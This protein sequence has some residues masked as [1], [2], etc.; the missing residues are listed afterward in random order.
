MSRAIRKLEEL[1]EKVQTKAIVQTINEVAARSKV[2][3]S[4]QIRDRY[5]IKAAD[6]NSLLDVSKANKNQA[7]ITAIV[8]A[9]KPS[10]RGLNLIRFGARFIQGRG[11]VKYVRAIV[12]GQWKMIPYRDGQGVTATINKGKRVFVPGAWIA[13]QLAGTPVLFRDKNNRV[14]GFTTLDAAGMFIQPTPYN[15]TVNFAREQLIK[16]VQRSLDRFKK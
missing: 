9:K 7:S 10:K 4:R 1:P 3:M 15:N 2:E 16:S 12:Q 8:K 5:N 6:V 11:Q 13:T 14:R